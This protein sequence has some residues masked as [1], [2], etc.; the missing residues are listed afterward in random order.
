VAIARSG[1]QNGVAQLPQR[2]TTS[3][4]HASGLQGQIDQLDEDW[5]LVKCWFHGVAEPP[6]WRT[7]FDRMR[8]T[9]DA[10]EH[11]VAPESSGG[12]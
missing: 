12:S 9:I 5:Y 6:A 8:A 2:V 7:L 11:D 10:I 4:A 1:T 3:K